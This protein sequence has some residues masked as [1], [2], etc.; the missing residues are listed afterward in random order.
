MMTRGELQ[1]ALWGDL[2]RQFV[3]VGITNTDD[4]G[5]LESPLDS[6][7][8]ALG[9][10]YA[11]RATGTVADGDES[12]ARVLARYYGLSAV[13][14]A[15]LG[16]VDIS[17]SAPG[18]SKSANQYVKDLEKALDV[19]KANAAPYLPD[20]GSWGIGSFSLDFIEPGCY[21]GVS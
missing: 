2:Q 13:Y 17:V 10:S 3:K 8:I 19:A 7:L 11:D 4:A 16:S 14:L 20:D 18:V 5:N 15:A 21:G 6:T 12:T 9:T 1:D